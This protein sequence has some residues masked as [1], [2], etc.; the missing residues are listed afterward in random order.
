MTPLIFKNITKLANRLGIY[1]VQELANYK[2][3]KNIET[4]QEFIR[5]LIYDVENA[6]KGNFN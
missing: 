4:T 6:P 3:P 5:S 1:T 2:K